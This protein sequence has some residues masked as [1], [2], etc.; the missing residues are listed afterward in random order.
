MLTVV[1]KKPK[2]DYVLPQNLVAFSGDMLASVK[3]PELW[4]WKSPADM[5]G[6]VGKRMHVAV[7][8]PADTSFFD[9]VIRTVSVFVVKDIEINIP[10]TTKTSA[11]HFVIDSCNVNAVDIYFST[12]SLVTLYYK[13]KALDA[14]LRLNVSRPD[15]YVVAFTA[16]VNV[17][18]VAVEKE[19]SIRIERRFKFSDIV[20][21]KNNKVL[22]VNNNSLNNNGYRFVN[23]EW[24]RDGVPVG[25]GRQYYYEGGEDAAILSQSMLYSVRVTT[26]DGKQISTCEAYVS[27]SSS[28]FKVY[29]NPVR[30]GS[31][32]NVEFPENGAGTFVIKLFSLS[33]SLLNTYNVNAVNPQIILNVN[34][35]TYVLKSEVGETLIVV[36]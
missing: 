12:D 33:G 36:N 23:Y 16:S 29:P 32:V 20:H 22:F 1:V 31:A 28:V 19:Q 14:L 30:S 10:G 26:D 25:D 4:H 24:F 6:A 21:S 8:V 7:F 15:V 9:T 11:G 2:P 27:Q 18:G 13:N 35:G 34:T 5:V 3:L 17:D